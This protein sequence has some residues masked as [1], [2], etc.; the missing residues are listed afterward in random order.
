VYYALQFD[1]YA[2]PVGQI[3]LNAPPL[4]LKLIT[5][6]TLVLEGIG[7]LFLFVPV[8]TAFFRGAT[9][10]SF[11]FLHVIFGLCFIIGVF[12]LLSSASWLAFIPTVFWDNLEKRLDIPQRNGLTIYYDK[13]CS[14]CKKVVYL[15]RTF[16][17]LPRTTL[18][19][20]Q[21]REDASI[22]ADMQEYNSWVVVDWQGNRRFKWDAMCYVVSLSP[23]FKLLASILRFPPLFSVGTKF[24]EIIARNRQTAG[25]FTRPLKFR[26]TVVRPSLI[27]NIIALLLILATF[28]WNIRTF[29]QRTYERRAVRQNDWISFTYHLFNRRTIQSVDWISRLTRLDQGWSIFAPAPPRDDGWYVIPGKLKD[30]SEV[31]VLRG[32]EKPVSWE[33]PTMQERNALYGD[34]HWRTFFIALNR[35]IGKKLYPTY[36][37][38][39]CREWNSKH[40]GNKKLESFEIFFMNERTVPPGEKQTVEKESHWKQDCK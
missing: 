38:Y 30:G 11:I 2:T 27:L 15:L 39:L 10:I 29:A 20:A 23:V 7:P 9:V 26:P 34:M 14:F 3:L 21:E 6:A 32:L 24:Y 22:Y 17:V 19:A 36:A 28:F 25:I 31:D 40:Q 13:E 37:R 18:L 16:L 8:Y 33:K 4:L 12:P 5:Y 35:A 1:P